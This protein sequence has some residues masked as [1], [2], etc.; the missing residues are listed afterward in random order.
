MRLCWLLPL[1]IACGANRAGV[2]PAPP[3]AT[4]EGK[5]KAKTELAAALLASGNAEATL[6]LIGKMRA[7]GASQ[8][9]LLVLQG[10]AM[11][12]LGLTDD[13]EAIL[14]DVA[15]RH[16]RTTDAHNALG[17][18]LMDQKRVDEAIPRFKAAVRAAP[19]SSDAL[20]NL[21]FALMAAGRH[22]EAVTTLREALSLDSSKLRTRN[23]LGFALV[24]TEQDEA[25][26]RVFRA[27]GDAVTAHSNL[28][29]AQ[30]IRGDNAAAKASYEA[31]LAADPDHLMAVEALRRLSRSPDKQPP[32]EVSSPPEEAPQ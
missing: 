3:W 6:R 21:G 13:A 8:P 11:A 20:N 9:E 31:V 15:R 29:M 14:G 27:G 1:A 7:Q 16:P 19:Q 25:A 26:F 17:I 32:T 22:A 2:E 5:E 28:A 4:S 18:L 12:K 24:A 10:K 23:N 30:E